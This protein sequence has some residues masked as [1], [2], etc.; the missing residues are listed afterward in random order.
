MKTL[1]S[2]DKLFLNELM[3]VVQKDRSM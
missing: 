3:F 1:Y 2:F